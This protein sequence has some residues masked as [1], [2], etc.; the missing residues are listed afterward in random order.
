MSKENSDEIVFNDNCPHC[1]KK[2]RVKLSDTPK[3]I[4]CKE[5]IFF[6]EKKPLISAFTAL[7]IGG[8]GGIYFQDNIANRYPMSTE[9]SILENCIS[10][11]DKPLRRGYYSDKKEICICAFRKTQ[12]VYEYDEFKESQSSFLDTFEEKARICSKK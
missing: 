4:H 1:D 11:Y 7:L 10:S 8:V 6:K 12:K 3:C 5:P 2:T 9:Y